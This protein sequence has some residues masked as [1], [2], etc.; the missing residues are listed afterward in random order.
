MYACVIKMLVLARTTFCTEFGLQSIESGR[1]DSRT[2]PLVFAV[3][4]FD[5][6]VYIA[7]GCLGRSEEN[8]LFVKKWAIV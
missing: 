4:Y 2:A 5:G 1:I 7:R 8:V 6:P 3:K